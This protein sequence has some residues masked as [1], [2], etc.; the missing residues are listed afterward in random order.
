VVPVLEMLVVLVTPGVLL[1]VLV[2]VVATVF[3][4]TGVFS[5]FLLGI[6]DIAVVLMVVGCWV[7]CW[8]CC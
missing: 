5:P 6:D 7:G 2:V 1:A 3:V 4:G 8:V